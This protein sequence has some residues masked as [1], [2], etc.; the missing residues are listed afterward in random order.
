MGTDTNGASG[1]L[2]RT[3]PKAGA[4]GT[5][6]F[7]VSGSTSAAGDADGETSDVGE[8][9]GFEV[10]VLGEHAPFAENVAATFE[11]TYAAGDA[12]ID[13]DRVHKAD[14]EDGAFAYVTFPGISEGRSGPN[15][16]TA[17]RVLC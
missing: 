8:P 7:A 13:P 3:I 11:L 6:T 12:W 14:S 15:R 2:H 4:A 16:S 9:H 5:G 17:E 1:I 10:T